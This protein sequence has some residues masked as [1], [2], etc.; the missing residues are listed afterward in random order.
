MDGLIRYYDVCV[1]ATDNDDWDDENDADNVENAQDDDDD[2][3]AF[4]M[5]WQ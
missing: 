1:Y 2:A 5:A 4:V 3:N